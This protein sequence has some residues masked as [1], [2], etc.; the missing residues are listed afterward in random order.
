MYI[1]IYIGPCALYVHT[2]NQK[3]M[4]HRIDKKFRG[5]FIVEI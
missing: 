2:K 5:F 1:H 4:S 3:I